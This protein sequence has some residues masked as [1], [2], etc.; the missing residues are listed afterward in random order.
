M[1]EEI[2]KPWPT[3]PKYQISSHG[4]VKGQNGRIMKTKKHIGYVWVNLAVKPGESRTFSIHRLVAQTFLPDFD[5]SLTVDH[6]NGKREDNRVENLRMITR[7][8]NSSLGNNN[9]KEIQKLLKQIIETFGYEKTKQILQ[10]IIGET[11]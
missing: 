3:N 9:Y 6:I 10:N 8:Y 2:W 11:N 1:N 7:E 5:E 4:R